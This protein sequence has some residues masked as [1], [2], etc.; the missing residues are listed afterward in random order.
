MFPCWRQTFKSPSGGCGIDMTKAVAS[1]PA[2]TES[3]TEATPPARATGTKSA[4]ALNGALNSGRSRHTQSI[5]GTCDDSGDCVVA[6][7]K[8]RNKGYRADSAQNTRAG[9]GTRTLDI[10][11][12]KL[13]LY[14]LSYARERPKSSRWPAAC[15]RR[16]PM[17]PPLE[18]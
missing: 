13:A 17:R 1:L 12:G 10:Q 15:Y 5:G 11:L 18:I 8:P 2:F 16:V 4:G 14:Q 9:E 7:R 6:A 3:A